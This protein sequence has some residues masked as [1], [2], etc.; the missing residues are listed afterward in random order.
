MSFM[1]AVGVD[2]FFSLLLGGLLYIV[3]T[4]LVPSRFREKVSDIV[5]LFPQL[6]YSFLLY[7]VAGLLYALFSL[8]EV[9]GIPIV[10]LCIGIASQI[11][12]GVAK[13]RGEEL[14]GLKMKKPIKRLLIG[15]GFVVLILLLSSGY[16]VYR[17][18]K[19]D[20]VVQIKPEENTLKPGAIEIVANVGNKPYLDYL[21]VKAQSPI[22]YV[23]EKFKDHDVVLLGEQHEIRENCKFFSDLIEP[24]YRRGGVRM[25]IWEFLKQKRSAEVNELLTAESFD[26]QRIVNIFREDYLYW[27]FQEYVD[28]LRSVW[29]LNHSLHGGETRLKVAGMA[30]DVDVFTAMCGTLWQKLPQ[31][32]TL[33]NAEQSYAAPI[34]AA[35]DRHEKAL[36]QVG[37][38]H[39]FSEYKQARI[40]D[41][42]MLGESTHDRMGRLLKEKYG[43]RVFQVS[44]HVRQ[45]QV[46]PYTA[47]VTTPLI[48]FLE[49]LYAE[50]GDTAIG[51]DIL[52]SPFALLR[53]TSG[54]YFKFQRYVTFSDIAQGYII[55]KPIEQLSCVKWI[56][57][58]VDDSDFQHLRAYAL[59]RKYIGESECKSPDQLDRKFSTLLKEGRRLN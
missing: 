6:K 29:V 52:N 37:Y 21:R 38:T 33:L 13:L 36:V 41:G 54:E 30:P 28:I 15:I 51:F 18:S 4:G 46:E 44:L 32:F 8:A 3:E 14:G 39:T 42:R 57:G 9:H 40:V 49:T 20:E 58:F 16:L 50:N 7:A 22:D 26:E 56:T 53:D 25:F 47:K 43:E 5:P 27:G 31:I 23:V 2:L 11:T 34:E 48:Q 12:R 10:L 17:I 24:A 35:L 55:L 45:D 59:Q 19:A 1:L